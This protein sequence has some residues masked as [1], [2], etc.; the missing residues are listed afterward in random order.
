MSVRKRLRQLLDSG[1]YIVAPGA[2]DPLSARLVEQAGF[3]V[4]YL[5]GGGHSRANG[6]PDIGLLTLPEITHHITMAVDATSIPVIADADTGYGNAIN[7]IRTVREFERTGVAG[8]HLE[9]QLAPKKC[10]HYEGKLII[11][12]EEMLGKI[13][14]AVDTRTDADMVII[15]RTDARAVEG[16]DAAI[17]RANRYLEAGA[18]MAFVEAPQTIEELARVAREV[19]GPVMANIFEGGKTPAIPAA[20]LGAM[21]FALG[22][23]PSQTHRAAIFAIR[24]VLDVLKTDGI[25]TRID[26]RLAT[27]QQREDVV[28]TAA[29]RALEAKY[30]GL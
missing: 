27:F 6:L 12:A 16:L 17:D 15:A 28:G 7:V 20:E 3:D 26:H 9:D 29:W 1:Q 25:T 4:V 8:F 14:A 2:Y 24:E 10:G 13:K 21:G 5:T 30:L 23:Y 11:P 22:I 19:K 18:D